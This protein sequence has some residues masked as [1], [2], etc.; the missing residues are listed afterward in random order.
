MI[1]GEDIERLAR[2]V[3]IQMLVAAPQC[4]T[5]FAGIGL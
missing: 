1:Y 4:W 5:R 2:E 3:V